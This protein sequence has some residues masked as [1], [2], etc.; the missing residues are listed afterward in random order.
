MDTNPLAAEP[1]LFCI[2]FLIPLSLALLFIAI[3]RVPEY[4]RLVIFRLGRCVGA[5]GPGL[6][7]LI[8]FIENALKV[9]MREQAREISENVMTKDKMRVAVDL[10]WRFQIIDPT[11]SVLQ[12]VNLEAAAKGMICTVLR[13]TLTDMYYE[14]LRMNRRLIAEEVEYELKRILRRCGTELKGVEIQEISIMDDG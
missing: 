9:D 11:Q 8:P 3:R 7:I 14:D 12:V 5:R 10:T 2:S 1:E 6:V 4:Q 13:K